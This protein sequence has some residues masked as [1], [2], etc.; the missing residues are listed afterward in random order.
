MKNT[1]FAL[2]VIVTTM[3]NAQVVV[4]PENIILKSG[5]AIDQVLSESVLSYDASEEI[6]VSEYL[7][8]T[9]LV[10][11]DGKA[12]D[13]IDIDGLYRNH[14]DWIK[15]QV[16]L[17]EFRAEDV[18]KRMNISFQFGSDRPDF[19]E[20]DD[21]EKFPE[22]DLEKG[23]KRNAKV[24]KYVFRYQ[25]LKKLNKALQSNVY[26]EAKKIEGLVD[27]DIFIDKEGKVAYIEPNKLTDDKR[28]LNYA[29]VR[30]RDIDFNDLEKSKKGFSINR[31]FSLINKNVTDKLRLEYGL[32]FY[33]KKD[34]FNASFQ[35]N[36]IDD[37]KLTLDS[38]Q[39]H[40]MA[41][42][43]YLSGY[44]KYKNKAVH[45]FKDSRKDIIWEDYV[46]EISQSVNPDVLVDFTIVERKEEPDADSGERK[47]YSFAVVESK[48]VFPGCEKEK[49]EDARFMCFNKG[50][51]RHIVSNFRYPEEARQ[52]GLSDKV[53]VTF[54]IEK[55]G[56]ISNVEIPKGEY[57]DLNI[58][59]IRL[60]C[61]LPNMDAA[62]Q[63]GKRVR[64]SYT[65]P[66]NFKLN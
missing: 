3:A 48:P 41:I 29:V 54:V 19:I 25:L 55:D 38:A 50:I 51:M 11:E 33:Q 6:V 52:Y 60:I 49:S 39:Y 2:F 62:M 37:E 8:V 27:L 20:F 16:D 5:M 28:L 18:G 30:L 42:A 35:W 9:C 26:T 58:E 40:K 23:L 53:Y 34:Y 56:S 22:A 59:G 17:L 32:A 43:A 61:L 47:T 1:L 63:R 4:V 31:T 65:V 66:I 45:Y 57:D 46:I 14:L 24:D 44:S 12:T 64:M 10:G 7:L 36:E 15:T 13:L 21:F